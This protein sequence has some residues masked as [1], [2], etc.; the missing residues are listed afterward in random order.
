MQAAVEIPQ[1]LSDF[2]TRVPP[3]AA[4]FALGACVVVILTLI[5]SVLILRRLGTSSLHLF[6]LVGIILLA[7]DLYSKLQ[8]GRTWSEISSEYLPHFA[9]GIIITF[10]AVAILERSIAFR[11]RRQEHRAEVKRNA[12]AALLYYVRSCEKHNL[13]FTIGDREELNDDLTIFNKRMANQVASMSKN[14][15]AHFE[16]AAQEVNKLVVAINND[17]VSAEDRQ[18]AIDESASALR[19]KYQECYEI[20]L[21]AAPPD[22]A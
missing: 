8:N 15:K 7:Y 19:T 5:F 3:A 18:R 10:L 12:L 14:E 20:F 1:P 16:A 6:I 17:N 4:W 13:H 11:D 21:R 9:S 2:L 22:A